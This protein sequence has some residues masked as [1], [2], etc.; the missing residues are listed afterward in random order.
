VESIQELIT[1]LRYN[2]DL[3]EA[4]RLA[5]YM[6]VGGALGFYIRALYRRFAGTISNRDGFSMTFPMLVLATVLVI[7]VVKSS[8]ALSLG[9]VGALSIVRFRAAIKEPEELVYLFFCI[10][11]GLALGAEYPQLAIG[12]TIVFTIFVMLAHRFRRSSPPPAMLLTISG[13]RQAAMAGDVAQIAAA[14]REALGPSKVQRIDVDDEQVQFRATVAPEQAGEIAAAITALQA[15]LP[16]CRL[17]YTN[18]EN[19]F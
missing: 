4:L 10:A 1:G 11:V 18:L 3:R 2:T 15:R 6:A 16:G 17:S 12:G 19:L 9:L 13:P 7:F 14:V 5:G 8:L